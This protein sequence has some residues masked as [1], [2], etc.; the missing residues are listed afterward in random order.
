MKNKPKFQK[1]QLVTLKRFLP[2]VLSGSTVAVL[3]VR[4]CGKSGIRYQVRSDEYPAT[5]V[6][7]HE[8]DL[9]LPWEPP[10]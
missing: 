9:A 4:D 8:E 7:A 1:D 2:P 3:D 10:L 6:W 5:P